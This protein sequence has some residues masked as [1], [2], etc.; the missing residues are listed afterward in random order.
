MGEALFAAV[1]SRGVVVS[2]FPR[3]ARDGDISHL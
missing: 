1:F 3:P 2:H